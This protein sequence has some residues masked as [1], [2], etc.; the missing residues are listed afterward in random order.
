MRRHGERGEGQWG[1][2]GVSGHGERGEGQWV[3]NGVSGKG[4]GW[5]RK[6]GEKVE[7]VGKGREGKGEK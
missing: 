7:K 4:E 5:E 3:E 1:E 6:G 2:N